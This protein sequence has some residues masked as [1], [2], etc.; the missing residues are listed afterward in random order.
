MPDPAGLG[1]VSLS[2]PQSWNMYAYARNNPTTFTDP[3][4]L[5]V[6]LSGNVAD[7]LEER[8]RLIANA[9]KKGEAALFKAV[10]GKNGNTKLVVDKA[11]AAV[12][13]G[14]HSVGYN[15]LVKAI[16]A[17]PTITVRLEDADSYTGPRDARG[18]VTVHLDRNVAPVDVIAPMRGLQNQVIPNPFSIIAGHEVLG[19]AL[20]RVLGLP[21]QE[22]TAIQVENELRQE[23]GLP[24]RGS[25]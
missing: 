4:G 2:N 10:T 15:L 5:E 19:H 6:A 17:E 25:Q 18:N 16:Y 13:H 14:K 7:K 21:Y 24:L 3:S 22:E 9:S 12:F 23:Q 8:K 20:S 11:K 1:A